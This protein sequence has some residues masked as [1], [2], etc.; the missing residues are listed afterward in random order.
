MS[1]FRGP[2]H[3]DTIACILAL[4]QIPPMGKTTIG[5]SKSAPWH[6]W[7][8]YE[9]EMGRVGCPDGHIG[10]LR[11]QTPTPA[12]SIFSTSTGPHKSF[13]AWYAVSLD[14]CLEYKLDSRT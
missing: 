12:A 4:D 11:R 6:A 13:S 9:D 7:E 10:Q 3:F 1:T 2:A 8:D 5:R 14:P